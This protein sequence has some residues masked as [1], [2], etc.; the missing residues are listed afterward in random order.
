MLWTQP[1]VVGF[2][3]LLFFFIF[4]EWSCSE[5]N[6]AALK[7]TRNSPKTGSITIGLKGKQPLW[8]ADSEVAVG[9]KTRRR[10]LDS[11]VS[12]LPV[13]SLRPLTPSQRISALLSCSWKLMRLHQ[14]KR[15]LSLFP[16]RCHEC[17][18]RSSWQL[19]RQNTWKHLSQQQKEMMLGCFVFCF[20]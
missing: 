17:F 5:N 3:L 18:M 13:S 19:Y 9:R 12:S 10:L 4:T 14:H 6:S 11:A 7:E 16:S 20:F 8:A 1:C 15:A 2:F